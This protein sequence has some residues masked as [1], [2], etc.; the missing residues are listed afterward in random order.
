M[1]PSSSPRTASRC[2]L[3]TAAKMEVVADY[4]ETIVCR[5]ESLQQRCQTTVYD[6]RFELD[7]DVY[8][9]LSRWLRYTRC[10][11]DTLLVAV[12]LM[13][14]FR[15]SSGIIMTQYN[16]HRILLSALLLSLKVALDPPHLY[17]QAHYANV[18]GV[19]VEELLRLERSFV[20][21]CDWSFTVSPSQ[22][23]EFSRNFVRH[24]QKKMD[25]A[26]SEGDVL[27]DFSSD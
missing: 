27:S 26:E 17:A 20:Q 16:Q 19:A 7:V 8:D 21:D 18:G 9:Y 2:P 10:D 5:R 15:A 13:D 22:F 11:S 1:H 3:S 25:G 6:A 4:L 24:I 23:D 14:R 12:I